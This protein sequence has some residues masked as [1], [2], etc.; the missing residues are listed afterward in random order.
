MR[1]FC[2]AAIGDVEMILLAVSSRDARLALSKFGDERFVVRKYGEDTVSARKRRG[3]CLAVKDV[4]CDACNS[5]VKS[6][7]RGFKV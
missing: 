7:H 4:L 2:D 1:D 5:E 3:H 6:F